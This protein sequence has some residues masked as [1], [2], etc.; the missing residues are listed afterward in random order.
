[1]TDVDLRRVMAR[2][3]ANARVLEGLSPA[4]RADF[5]CYVRCCVV[6]GYADDYHTRIDFSDPGLIARY[7]AGAWRGTWSDR[8]FNVHRRQAG[9]RTYPPKRRQTPDEDVTTLMNRAGFPAPVTSTADEAL[10][11]L[12]EATRSAA[13]SLQLGVREIRL[14]GEQPWAKT[15]WMQPSEV[16]ALQKLIDKGLLLHEQGHPPRLSEAG[17]LLRRLLVLS[18]HIVEP[19]GPEA[20]E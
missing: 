15:H 13:F 17:R 1:M 8:W 19:D 9:C 16:T 6:G 18:R 3:D 14:L 7:C 12:A 5:L 20:S 11:R 2:V 4:T 10:D